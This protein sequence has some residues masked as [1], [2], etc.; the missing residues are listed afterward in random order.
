MTLYDIG[1]KGKGNLEQKLPTTAAKD[2]TDRLAHTAIVAVLLPPVLG[3]SAM[4]GNAATVYAGF[5]LLVGSLQAIRADND[6]LP[7]D[8]SRPIVW[9]AI[10]CTAYL[11]GPKGLFDPYRIVSLVSEALNLHSQL[12]DRLPY[13][14]F[15]IV[16]VCGFT[17]ISIRMLLLLQEAKRSAAELHL[18]HV[19]LAQLRHNL[20]QTVELRVA[21]LEKA[22]RSLAVTFREKAETLA[23]MAVLEERS[24]IAYEI[25]DTVGYTLTS[26]IVQLEAAKKIAEQQD[27]VPWEKLE[28]LSGLVRKGLEDVGRAVK[29]IRSDDAETMTL[30]AALR[31]LIQYTEDT[32][33]IAIDSDISLSS[34]I[35]PGRLTEQ[36]LYHALQEGLTNAA[37]HGKCIRVRFSLR[38][39]NGMLLFRLVSDGE[40]Y[41][42]AVPGFGLSSMIERVQLLDGRV[43]IR[44]SADAEGEPVG[45]ELSIDL[46]LL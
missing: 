3:V 31:E 6:L 27:R 29:L 46:P 12:S 2:R 16:S 23:E 9:L 44:S 10:A 40:P 32:M 39:S 8:R 24:R 21:A 7:P 26:A 36:V 43:N 14:V 1:I 42:S 20:E 28:L 15:V 37:R 4:A 25:H 11:L 38:L 22:S 13:V 45:C 30:E 41:G 18:K 17:A 35:K 34:N 5:A 19:E 33:E